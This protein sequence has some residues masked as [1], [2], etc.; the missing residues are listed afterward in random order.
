MKNAKIMLA[1]T[2]ISI[3]ACD[4]NQPTTHPGR[5]GFEIIDGLLDVVA[6]SSPLLGGGTPTTAQAIGASTCFLERLQDRVE[7]ADT[8][9]L[10]TTGSQHEIVSR[11]PTFKP[12][13]PH[14]QQII[15]AA[16]AVELLEQHPCEDH[17]RAAVN[18][19]ARCLPPGIEFGD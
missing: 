16:Q 3:A 13:E 14:G 15:Q 17:H 2:C 12:S 18:A 7:T 6:C 4:P 11:P 8:L 9:E 1:L 10:A 5:I 19:V